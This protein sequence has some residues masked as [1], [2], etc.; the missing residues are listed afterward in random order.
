M[1]TRIRILSAAC[2]A[3]GLLP[4]AHAADPAPTSDWTVPMSVTLVSDYI[5]LNPCS[6]SRKSSL[7]H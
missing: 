2:A 1:N 4:A 3:L 5:F 6:L 7:T